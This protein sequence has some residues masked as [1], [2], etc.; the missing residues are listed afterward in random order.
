MAGVVGVAVLGVRIAGSYPVTM[1][2][3]RVAVIAA[4]PDVLI[5]SPFIVARYPDSSP[6][7]FLPLLIILLWRGWPLCADMDAQGRV[8]RDRS[9][10]REP[11][12][13]KGCGG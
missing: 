13:S 5:I 11:Q 10:A 2:M 6:I 4:D 3:R 1:P 7:R 8:G 12:E 9:D